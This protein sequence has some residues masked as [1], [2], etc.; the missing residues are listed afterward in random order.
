MIY[1]ALHRLL[2]LVIKASAL[3]ADDP[4][5]DS[6]CRCGDFCGLSHTSD[7]KL[8]APVANLL[9]VSAGTG[10]PVSVYCDWVR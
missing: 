3:K 10:Y 6:R 9:G 4:E 8:G 1:P 5:F 2:G 7:L